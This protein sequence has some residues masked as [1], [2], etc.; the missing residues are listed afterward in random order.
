MASE[1]VAFSATLPL[2]TP[3]WTSWSRRGRVVDDHAGLGVDGARR[4]DGAGAHVVPAVGDARGAPLQVSVEAAAAE[5]LLLSWAKELVPV[6]A[7]SRKSVP[8]V[9]PPLFTT[10]PVTS[11]VPR[12]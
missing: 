11:T 6:P 7:Y 12:R 8:L 2:S 9:G 10:A 1:A 5:Q 3:A 4:G